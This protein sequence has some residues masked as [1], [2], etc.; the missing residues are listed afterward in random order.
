MGN[1]KLDWYDLEY[2]FSYKFKERFGNQTLKWI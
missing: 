2:K 1:K